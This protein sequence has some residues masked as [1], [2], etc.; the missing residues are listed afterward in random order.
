M[1]LKLPSEILI[2]PLK[3]SCIHKMK[4][5]YAYFTCTGHLNTLQ[6]LEQCIANSFALCLCKPGF[7]FVCSYPLLNSSDVCLAEGFCQVF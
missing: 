4:L 2:C 1:N 5:I 6:I 3:M 7:H